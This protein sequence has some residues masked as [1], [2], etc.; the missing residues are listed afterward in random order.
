[1]LNNYDCNKLKIFI[2]CPLVN[3]GGGERL[4]IRLVEALSH[5]ND[6]IKVRLAIPPSSLS[7]EQII[8]LET[9]NIDLY[10]LK[11]NQ[12]FIGFRAWLIQDNPIMGL[13]GS[14]YFRRLLRWIF[15]RNRDKEI[16]IHLKKGVRDY[17]LIYVF[18]PHL[19]SFPDVGKPVV[20]T[21]QDA[22]HLEYPEILGGYL[23]NLEIRN[24]RN[25]MKKST[26]VIV[27]S[28][29]TRDKLSEFFGEG[30]NIYPVIH[31]AIIPGYKTYAEPILPYIKNQLPNNWIVYP[32]NITAHKNHYN[33]LLAW[34]KYAKRNETPLILFGSGTELLNHKLGDPYPN[35]HHLERIIGLIHRLRLIPGNDFI[36]LGYV[37]DS[38]VMPIIKN[39]YAL[40][41]PSLAEGGGSYPVE[42]ALS[43][44]TPVLCS[45]IPVM[46]EH[47]ALRD[48]RIGW[49][50]PTSP[51]SIC[52]ALNELNRN[53][54][55]F[56]RSALKNMNDKRP[57]WDGIASH[58][59]EV[60]KN[61]LN[62]YSR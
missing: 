5:N 3:Q 29:S 30:C 38:Q 31:H 56:K 44:G 15:T 16:L 10:W 9:L 62:S 20:C 33:L 27:S 50:D 59:V 4:L 54:D 51:D 52:A 19:Q 42:E 60:F 25:W 28:K 55:L 57:T 26:Q 41:M 11:Q 2:W 12:G 47:L 13:K 36:A 8:Y 37:D 58:Y 35:N 1:M 45:N 48:A 18:W 61:A 14:I 43:L 34:S 6:I 39:A 24:A 49:F 23:N 46:K 32:A 17:D 22:T 53:Y 21:W 7:S 40:I